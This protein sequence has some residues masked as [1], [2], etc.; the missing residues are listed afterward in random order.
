M[1]QE[2]IKGTSREEILNFIDGRSYDDLFHL[3]SAKHFSL[4]QTYELLLFN[5]DDCILIELTTVDNYMK[6]YVN[7][8]DIGVDIIKMIKQFIHEFD[9]IDSYDLKEFMSNISSSTIRDLRDLVMDDS[10]RYTN[11]V[12]KKNN[13]VYILDDD[14]KIIRN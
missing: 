10:K 4:Q 11:I 12:Y 6:Y 1:L 5:Y 7:Y 9:D 14:D 13:V 8:Y 2:Y 3:L